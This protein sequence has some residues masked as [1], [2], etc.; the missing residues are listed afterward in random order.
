MEEA[1][2][3]SLSKG[4]GEIPLPP[5]VTLNLLNPKLPRLQKESP[6][7]AQNQERRFLFH[8]V[9]NLKFSPH[10]NESLWI[11]HRI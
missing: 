6:L 4:K 11:F 5:E 10:F 2:S 1:L 7:G 8:K 9:E 3:P